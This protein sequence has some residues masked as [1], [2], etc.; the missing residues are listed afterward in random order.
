MREAD[1]RRVA[2][3]PSK[4][5]MVF[6]GDCHF[7]R[8]WVE[9][10]REMT[11]GEVDYAPSQEVGAQFPEIPAAE[12]RRRSSSSNGRHDLEWR[13]GRFPLV[14]LWAETRAARAAV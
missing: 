9:R 3:P 5:L 13:G 12:F 6:D 8:R 14:R 11:R 4:P 7:C 1:H 2:N 10:W